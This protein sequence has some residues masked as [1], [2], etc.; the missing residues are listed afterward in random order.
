LV[1]RTGN[2]GRKATRVPPEIDL[3]GEDHGNDWQFAKAKLPLWLG[4]LK[5]QGFK[6]DVY[7]TWNK[8]REN[9]PAREIQGEPKRIAALKDGEKDNVILNQNQVQG[10]DALVD[11]LADRVKQYAKIV[12]SLG[13]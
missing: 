13:G 5:S 2:L 4:T 10:E 3:W 11:L 12:E 1:L 7:Q 6:W 9:A 8:T